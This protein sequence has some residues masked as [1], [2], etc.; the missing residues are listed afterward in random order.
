LIEKFEEDINKFIQ[1][2]EQRVNNSIERHTLD[3]I[4]E[5]RL[6]EEFEEKLLRE[7]EAKLWREL[8]VIFKS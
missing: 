2:E 1:Y 7:S 3:L 8:N 5:L 6:D 4:E